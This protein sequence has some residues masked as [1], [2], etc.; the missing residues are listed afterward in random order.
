MPALWKAWV[1]RLVLLNK[2]K[3]LFSSQDFQNIGIGCHG[4]SY[5]IGSEIT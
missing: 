3:G 4:M 5:P 2:V 1:L